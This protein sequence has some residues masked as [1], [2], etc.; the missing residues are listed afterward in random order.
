MW[1]FHCYEISLPCAR[2]RKMDQMVL[3]I[4]MVFD[5]VNPVFRRINL[6]SK[7]NVVPITLGVEIVFQVLTVRQ[8]GRLL[9]QKC[10]ITENVGLLL[11]GSSKPKVNDSDWASLTFRGCYL[12]IQTRM[13][14]QSTTHLLTMTMYFDLSTMY[15]PFELSISIFFASKKSGLGKS[16]CLLRRPL[17][18]GKKIE[19]YTFRCKDLTSA[20]PKSIK[21]MRNNTNMRCNF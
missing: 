8:N 6:T 14:R 1:T 16:Y 19:N 10:R 5:L 13:F 20:C 12:Q 21:E 9:L 11:V 17:E 2:T 4:F 18:N 15:P 3:K 7:C